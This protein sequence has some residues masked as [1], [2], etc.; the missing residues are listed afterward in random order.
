MIIHKWG[1]A[2]MGNQRQ[3]LDHFAMENSPQILCCILQPYLYM[4]HIKLLNQ[5]P[6]FVF[7]WVVEGGYETELQL[8][9]VPPKIKACVLMVR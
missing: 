7:F 5:W 4:L 9:Y 6:I 3:A 1:S 8:L 2:A